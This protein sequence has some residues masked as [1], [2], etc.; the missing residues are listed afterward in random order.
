MI[1]CNR[2]YLVAVIGMAP[3]S[4]AI[5]SATA[6]VEKL[7]RHSLFQRSACAYPVSMFY[8]CFSALTGRIA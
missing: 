5:S 3:F 1:R 8:V 4:I 7:Q 6:I 2:W